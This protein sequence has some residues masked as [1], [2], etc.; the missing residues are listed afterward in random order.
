MPA[1]MLPAAEEAAPMAEDA[2]EVAEPRRPPLDVEE[3]EPEV[4]VEEREAE[5]L[6]EEAEEE[7]EPPV[8]A[9]QRLAKPEG[10]KGEGAEGRQGVGMGSDD[11]W[12]CT[13]EISSR[14]GCSFRRSS[15]S[16]STAEA[17]LKQLPQERI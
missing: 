10:W 16:L 14:S 1:E 5:A 11:G 6:P 17:S 7:D 8:A 2:R 9:E 3:A 15:S 13:V 4:R 12:G